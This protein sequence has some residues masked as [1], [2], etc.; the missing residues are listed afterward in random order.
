MRGLKQGNDIIRFTSSQ[1]LNGHSV[2]N[3]L[4][5]A[6]PQGRGQ[7]RLFQESRDNEGE[8]EETGK[9]F[10]PG[11]REEETKQGG[12][13]GRDSNDKS[14]RDRLVTESVMGLHTAS[15]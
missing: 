1:V 5:W 6:K 14:Q 2:V 15:I 13:E 12:L 11:A 4:E 10:R 3:G 8:A 9:H 7:L